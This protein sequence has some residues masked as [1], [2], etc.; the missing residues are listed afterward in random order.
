M[1]RFEIYSPEGLRVDGRRWNEIRRFECRINSHPTSSDG[2]SYVEQGNTKVLC[3][4]QGP[5]E[6][7]LRSQS[8]TAQGSLIVNVSVTPFATVERNKRPRN[9]RRIQELSATL[10]RTFNKAIVLKNYPRSLIQVNLQVLALDGGL[11][12]ACTNATTLALMDAGISMYDYI[13]SVT[14]GIF[15]GQTPLLDLNTIEENELGFLTVGVIGESEKLA[16]LLME[17]RVGMDSLEKVLAIAIAGSHR[18]R[19]LMD[20]QVRNYGKHKVAKLANQ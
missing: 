17:D 20:I 4:V 18:I 6:P 19:E 10:T 2:S 15:D 5:M 9:D 14:A 13:S 8:S 11:L 1:S 3:L 7:A 16:L 12:A